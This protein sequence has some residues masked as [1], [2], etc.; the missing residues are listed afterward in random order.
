MRKLLIAIAVTVPALS[1]GQKAGAD[2]AADAKAILEQA[3]KASG[4]EKELA[5]LH[6]TTSKIKGKIHVQGMEVAFDGDFVTQG[7]DQQKVSLASEVMGQKLNVVNVFNKGNGWTKVNNDTMDLSKDK[8]DEARDQAYGSWISTLLP[9]REKGFALAT[10]GETAVE[11]KPAVGIR[12][13]RKGNR[14]VSIFF[15]K[16]SMLIVKTEGRV[17]DEA[18]GQE[19]NEESFLSG[20]DPKFANQPKK[21]TIKRDGKLFMEAEISEMKA[22]EKLDD[23]FFGKP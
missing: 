7:E 3:I 14:D 18:T 16:K 23:S 13:S 2:D 15:D 19:V 6:T 12:V 11:D 20:H 22:E 8:I 17:K 1:V 4:G 10:T 5:K 9:L 21:L